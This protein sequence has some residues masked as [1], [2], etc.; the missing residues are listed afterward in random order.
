MKLMKGMG[1]TEGEGLGRER[2]G[3]AT[4]IIMQKTDTRTG[5][6]VNAEPLNGPA[7]AAAAAAQAA[8]AAAV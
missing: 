8:A 7:A 4:P 6:I 3:M 2:Q 1:W 5:V